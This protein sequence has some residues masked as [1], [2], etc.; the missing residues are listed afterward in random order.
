MSGK[1]SFYFLAFALVPLF[2]VLQAPERQE[3]FHQ[4]GLTGLKPFL[5]AGQ[6]ISTTLQE[7]TS[8]FV[9]FWNLYRDHSEL[10]KRVA[11]LEQKQVE[12][13]ELRK[14]NTRLRE[15]LEFRK[16]IPAKTVAARVIGRDLVPWRRTILID[17]GSTQG[18]KKRMAVVSAQGLVGRIVATRPPESLDRIAD[19]IARTRATPAAA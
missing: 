19:E 2:F 12:L 4:I 1:R 9:Q 13:E 7:T 14:E 8:R 18:I 5:V 17:K 6:A 10:V 11:E 15:L 3:V 16:E